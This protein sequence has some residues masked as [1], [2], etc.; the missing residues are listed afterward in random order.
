M[1]LSL[2][3]G[4]VRLKR[5]LFGLA[6]FKSYK[7]EGLLGLVGFSLQCGLAGLESDLLEEVG[8][9]HFVRGEIK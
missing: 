3:C 5:G 6:S 2:Q 7:R 8:R 4:L 9:L 1:A